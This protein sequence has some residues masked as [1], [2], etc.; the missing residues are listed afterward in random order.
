MNDCRVQSAR[1][2]KGST[3]T[4]ANPGLV[5]YRTFAETTIPGSGCECIGARRT[6]IPK[7]GFTLALFPFPRGPHQRRHDME[8]GLRINEVDKWKF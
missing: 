5:E 4:P 6:P 3:I 1:K 7:T 2:K 8:N